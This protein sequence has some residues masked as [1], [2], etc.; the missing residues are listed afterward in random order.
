M[1]TPVER[2]LILRNVDLLQGVGP[3]DLAVLAGVAREEKI[4]EGQKIYG[5]EDLADCLYV[6]VE[7]RVRLSTGGRM[8]GEMGVGEAFGTW[9]L[10]DDSARGQEAVCLEDGIVLALEREEF[11][12]A[13]AD[14]PIFLKEL[15]RLLARRLRKLVEER[16]EDAQVE[17]EKVERVEKPELVETATSREE[18]RPGTSPLAEASLEA[19]VLDRPTAQPLDKKNQAS[20][21]SEGS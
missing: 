7:G 11:Y 21:G 4:W 19:A 8:I 5:E 18:P 16:P 3:R 9:S 13:A 1:L 20:E 17:G 6:I 14:S 15:L 12:E 2:V 10:V